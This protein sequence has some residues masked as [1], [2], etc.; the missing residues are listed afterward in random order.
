[1]KMDYSLRQAMERRQLTL[2]YQ[3]QVDLRTGRMTGAEAL[4]RWTDEELGEVSPGI[5]I[6]LAEETGFIIT[7]GAW[8][9][10]EAVRQAAIWQDAGTPVMISVNVSALQFRQPDFV[11]RVADAIRASGLKAEL[12]EL[13]LTESILVQDADEALGRLNALSALGVSLAIDDFGTGYSNLAYLKKFPLHKL[14]IDR[15]FIQG[16]PDDESDLAIITAVTSLGHALRLQVVA[17]GVETEAQRNELIKLQCD[18]YQGFL[19]SP[20]LPAEEF[21]RM[22]RGPEPERLQRSLVVEEG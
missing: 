19:C 2:H 17:E 3:P 6:P 21:A 11:D 14:K 7:I 5:F 22:L 1:M 9:L 8:V 16:L 20:G 18:Q 13:E 15:S 12:L 4:A 10:E